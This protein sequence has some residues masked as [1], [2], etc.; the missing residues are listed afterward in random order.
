MRGYD[1]KHV[2]LS[3]DS[4]MYLEFLHTMYILLIFKTLLICTKSYSVAHIRKKNT[5]MKYIHFL[6][7][8]FKRFL[9][10]PS[11]RVSQVK[12]AH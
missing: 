8:I 5:Y 10:I 4:I 7:I 2:Y 3:Q 9:R 6:P 1:Q 11:N 12:T